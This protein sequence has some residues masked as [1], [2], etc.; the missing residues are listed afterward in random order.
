M[1]T[2]Q[3]LKR[4]YN[5]FLKVAGLAPETFHDIILNSLDLFNR[6]SEELSYVY[7]KIQK[8]Y[9][10]D[11][12]RLGQNINR[13][14]VDNP[15]GLGAGF[16]KEG[17]GCN[18]WPILGFGHAELGSVTHIPQFGSVGKR[19]QRVDKDLAIVNRLGLPNKGAYHLSCYMKDYLKTT[20]MTGVSLAKSVEVE[21]S[22]SG[23][24][25]VSSFLMLEDNADYFTLNLSCPN[26]IDSA[27]HLNDYLWLSG[28]IDA[29]QTANYFG[30]PIYVKLSADIT[31]PVLTKVLDY[32]LLNRVSGVILSNASTHLNKYKDYK[33]WGLSG[34]PILQR[35]LELVS[36]THNYTN[37]RLNIIGIG[38]I[39]DADDAWEYIIRGARLV[40]VVSGFVYKGPWITKEINYGLLD[41]LDE[42][43]FDHISEAVGSKFR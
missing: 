33:G 18:I 13:C 43:G 7:S 32:C 19:L 15:V 5:T 16:D 3:I 20:T 37:G 11:D 30:L 22:R 34:K 12:P 23:S 17:R 8:H 10:I 24:D 38:G 27:T 42:H 21:V 9:L 39:F 1:T 35:S 29:V 6:Y 41:K 2:E 26:S 31:I 25:F 36:I 40:Q 28:V 14:Y 4:I